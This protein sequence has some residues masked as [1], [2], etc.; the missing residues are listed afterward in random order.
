MDITNT[1]YWLSSAQ[2]LSSQTLDLRRVKSASKRP[3]RPFGQRR[4]LSKSLSPNLWGGVF[5]SYKFC[6]LL[7]FFPKKCVSSVSKNMSPKKTVSSHHLGVVFFLWGFGVGKSHALRFRMW[8]LRFLGTEFMTKADFSP[9]RSRNSWTGK[10]LNPSI[11]KNDSCFGILQYH[12]VK[13]VKN[14]FLP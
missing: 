7:G 11:H 8:V 5:C 1:E 12:L 2:S 14:V 6:Q 13:S 9:S 4:S 3:E 10:N